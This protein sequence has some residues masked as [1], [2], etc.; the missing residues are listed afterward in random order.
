MDTYQVKIIKSMEQLKNCPV[1]CVD[2][3]QW[4]KE[5]RP[6]TYGQMAL[7]EDYGLVITMT[8]LE[9]EPLRRYTLDDSPVYKD[10]CME[11]F[12]NFAPEDMEKGYINFEMNSNGA[13]LSGFGKDRN[14]KRL[15]QITSYHAICEAKID[16]KSWSIILR[17]PMELIFDVYQKDVLKAGDIFTCN[18]YKISEDPSIEHYAS[19]SPIE[20]T[21]PNFHLPNFFSKAI[22]Q[23]ENK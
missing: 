6:Q 10:S 19:Y 11:A 5:Y 2:N 14:R 4:T 15:N 22:I 12:L 9:V 3:Y 13:M 17:I 1:F 18:F 21:I 7:L 8:T 16:E 20:S 23:V